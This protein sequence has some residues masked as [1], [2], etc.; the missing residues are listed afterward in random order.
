MR[1]PSFVLLAGI[2]LLLAALPSHAQEKP[3]D[4]TG[5]WTWTGIQGYGRSSGSGFSGGG[6][7]VKFSLELRA[8]GTNLTG[9]L[10]NS[11][12]P[13][14]MPVAMPLSDGRI[15]GSN[16]SFTVVAQSENGRTG[17]N[18]FAGGMDGPDALK[19]TDLGGR[20]QWTA[21]RA[22]AAAVV[23]AEAPTVE[24][25]LGIRDISYPGMTNKLEYPLGFRIK[26]TGTF[27]I[28]AGDETL[29]FFRGTVHIQPKDG[30]EKQVMFQHIWRTHIADVPPGETVESPSYGD[31][32]TYFPAAKDGDY[33]V[34]W[35]LDALKSNVL[36]FNVTGGKIKLVETN[37]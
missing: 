37:R 33:E 26:N 3:V 12:L 34:W 6:G 14:A 31:L 5:T 18:R 16:F 20:R 19:G 35:T 27:K 29:L 36:K 30:P 32:L 24:I 22:R 2:A 13:G 8:D 4:P 28:K 21:T 23:K 1:A 11:G 25:S 15:D 9:T 17:T 10:I 7:T